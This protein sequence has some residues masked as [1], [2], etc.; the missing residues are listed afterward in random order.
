MMGA[1]AGDFEGWYRAEHGR[2]VAALAV[3]SGSV[4]VAQ[5][6]VSEAFAR[7]LERWERV[8]RMDSPTGWVRQVAVNLL[9][10]RFRRAALEERL[11]RRDPPR[12]E[13]PPIPDLEPALWAAVLDLPPRQRAVIGLRVVLDLSQ[14]ET[15]RLL[16]IQPA[17]VSATLSQARKHLERTLADETTEATHA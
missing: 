15:A 2:L 6:V 9:R 7:A 8:S 5:D 11:L 4:E 10:R 13:A 1:V 16:G 14:E 17:T 3:S 12:D